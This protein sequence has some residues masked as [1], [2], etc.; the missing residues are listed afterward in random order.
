M[1]EV[2]AGRFVTA[3]LGKRGV[4]IGDSGKKTWR[5]QK[6][7]RTKSGSAISSWVTHCV[8]TRGDQE[9]ENL[10]RVH[11]RDR[12]IPSSEATSKR[13]SSDG[14]KTS[15]RLKRIGIEGGNQSNLT[16]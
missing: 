9:M 6:G 1:G 14:R 13:G 3:H 8:F 5:V 12:G 16:G 10:I 2:E 7:R 4:E 15:S 11:L